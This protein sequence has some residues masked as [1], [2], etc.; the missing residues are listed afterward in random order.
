MAGAMPKLITSAR[1]SNCTPNSV[2]VFVARATRPSS[3]SKM[4]AST[5]RPA[6]HRK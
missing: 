6:A 1:L 5:S 2:A 3:P 4:P